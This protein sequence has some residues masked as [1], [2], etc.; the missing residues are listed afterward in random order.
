MHNT[1]EP[2]AVC[3]GLDISKARLDACLLAAGKLHH[4][5]FDNTPDG[6]A[7]LRAWCA[8]LGQPS[9][10]TVLEATGRYGQLAAETLHATG[11]PVHIANP[12]RVKDHARSLG[13]RNKT[14]RIDA[15]LIAHFGTTR[16][17]PLWQPAPAAQ[18]TLGLLQRRVADLHTLI[19]SERNRLESAASNDIK[20]S[21]RRILRALEK[22]LATLEKQATTLI[23]TEPALGA[24]IGRLCAVEGIGE[25]TA[26]WLVAEVPRHLPNA[27]A[28]AAWLAV[29]PRVQQSGCSIR[30]TSPIGTEGNRHLRRALFMAA[31]VAR[32]HNPRFKT[33]ADRLAASGKSKMSVL[34]AVLHKLFKTAFA[35]LK[36]QSSY[37]PLHLSKN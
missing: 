36:N 20:K 7:A 22:E 14:D 8:K 21:I 12:R 29:T 27:R 2:A 24:D 23:A 25:R 13:R 16:T 37:D 35:L 19:Q 3:L 33:F 1:P 9:P 15:A 31:M 26:R 34:F 10:L 17:L 28:A 5:R 4:A 6:L 30:H 18:A 32:R 11:H